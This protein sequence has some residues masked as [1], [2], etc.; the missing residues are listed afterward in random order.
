MSSDTPRRRAIPV[1]EG[2]ARL[3]DEQ[4]GYEMPE[5]NHRGPMILALAIGVLIVF[6]VVVWNAYKQGVRQNDAATLPQIASEGAFKRRPDNPGGNASAD[7]DKRVFD[8]IDGAYRDDYNGQIAETPETIK[9][10]SNLKG[11]TFEGLKFISLSPISR[12]SSFPAKTE[13]GS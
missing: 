13:A 1:D 12:A 9:G 6:G 11:E 7:T 5:E 8:Q 10:E 4:A 2:F 3:P